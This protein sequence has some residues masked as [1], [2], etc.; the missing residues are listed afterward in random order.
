M[1]AIAPHREPAYAK[2]NLCLALG[3]TRPDGRH[4]LVT[5]FQ[6]VTLADELTFELGAPGADDEVRCPGVEGENLVAR[7][8]RALREA[9]WDGPP[10]RVTID[11]RIPVAAGMGGGSADA[12]AVLRHAARLAPLPRPA[13]DEIAARLGADVPAQLA[14]GASIGLGAGDEVHA[15]AALAPHSVLVLP[16][17]A[18]LSTADVYREAD[19]LGLGRSADE[20]RDLLGDLRAALAALAA[21]SLPARLIVNDLQPAAI[22]LCPPIATAL[23]RALGSGADQAIVCGSGPTVIGLFWGADAPH[24]A[25]AAAQRAAWAGAALVADPVSVLQPIRA[26]SVSGRFS[27]A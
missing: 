21:G 10:L 7:A 6:S 14:P 1:T 8:L 23:E 25:R 26:V 4:E 24:R 3:P 13:L 5:L 9:G 16:Q 15:V 19:R 20:L 18:A 11:K 17:R 12:A 27:G 22:S 2:V